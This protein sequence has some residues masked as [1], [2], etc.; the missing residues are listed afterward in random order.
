[1]IGLVAIGTMVSGAGGV[2]CDLF[3]T[4]ECLNYFVADGYASEYVVISL[5]QVFRK[6]NRFDSSDQG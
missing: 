1:M 6:W 5:E 2:A 4:D 3:K